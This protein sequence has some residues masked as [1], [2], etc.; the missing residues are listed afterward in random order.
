MNANVK[1]T[2]TWN[3]RTNA[4]QI[5]FDGQYKVHLIYNPSIPKYNDVF[6]VGV[7]SSV[8]PPQDP[9]VVTPEPPVIIPTPPV[10]IPTPPVEKVTIEYVAPDLTSGIVPNRVVGDKGTS[11]KISGQGSMV[12]NGYVFKGWIG[13]LN[14]QRVFYLPDSDHTLSSNLTLNAVW[15]AVAPKEF[16][17]TYHGNGNTSG[18]APEAQRFSVGKPFKLMSS[19]TLQK[20]RA[21]FLGW[22]LKPDQ[23]LWTYSEGDE[24]TFMENTGIDLYAIWRTNPSWLENSVWFSQK[25]PKGHESAGVPRDLINWDDTNLDT[26][27]ISG[28]PLKDWIFDSGCTL[29]SFS[30]M[31]RNADAETVQPQIDYRIESDSPQKAYL[32]ADPYVVTLANLATMTG[33]W[34][35]IPPNS[36]FP[37]SNH[38]MLCQNKPIFTHFRQ[39][40]TQRSFSYSKT[41]FKDSHSAFYKWGE[42]RAQLDNPLNVGGI[43]LR[44]TGNGFMHSIV[45]TDYDEKLILERPNPALPNGPVVG[46]ITGPIDSGDPDPGYS[47]PDPVEPPYVV[48]ST[49]NPT[50]YF[51]DTS[52]ESQNT[53]NTLLQMGETLSEVNYRFNPLREPSYDR[54]YEKTL[55]KGLTVQEPAAFKPSKDGKK[56][57]H[58]ARLIDT[59]NWRVMP[60]FAY[61]R[62]CESLSLK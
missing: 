58:N 15:E 30:I 53:S 6:N 33:A 9:P 28:T 42:I 50:E 11:I 43:H 61:L 27:K 14:T 2:F 51:S 19:G 21:S 12:K 29:V 36:N 7:K 39:R 34:Q 47:V 48:M 35:N 37:L 38:P 45:F 13:L 17:V 49:P 52:F 60:Y 10:I 8:T 41:D 18:N 59:W 1:K 3:G 31:L 16:K 46:P 57:G 5:V 40:G 56:E 26:I 32:P 54:E 4:G 55:A 25:V 20:H 44:W 24:V 22:G 23:L 62:K